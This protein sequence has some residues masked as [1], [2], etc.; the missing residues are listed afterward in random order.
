MPAHPAASAAAQ[1]HSQ[2]F[3]NHVMGRDENAVKEQVFVRVSTAHK[4][5][6][7]PIKRQGNLSSTKVEFTQENEGY[8]AVK[9]SV[10]K[11][12]YKKKE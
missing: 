3:E 9:V 10:Y 11:C 8:K 4:L 12:T 5:F 7:K 2:H 6:H 1:R